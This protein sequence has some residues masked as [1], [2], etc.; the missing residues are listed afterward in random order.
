M[1]ESGGLR[2]TRTPDRESWVIPFWDR[3]DEDEFEDMLIGLRHGG[4]DRWGGAIHGFK[5]TARSAG[6]DGVR[7]YVGSDLPGGVTLVLRPDSH[8]QAADVITKVLWASMD[9]DRGIVPWQRIGAH[10]DAIREVLLSD[11]ESEMPSFGLSALI[12]G[13]HEGQYIEAPSSWVGSGQ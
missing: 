13:N 10:L 3:R 4:P 5:W 1:V 12:R 8:T 9:T 2:Y 11:Q 7:F 6:I